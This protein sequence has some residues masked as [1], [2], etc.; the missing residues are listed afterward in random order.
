MI[1]TAAR[2]HHGIHI[3]RVAVPKRQIAPR[4]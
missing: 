1:L 2:I 4:R 3:T